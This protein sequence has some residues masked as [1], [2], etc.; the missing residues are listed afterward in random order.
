MRHGES[1]AN[2]DETFAGWLDVP[3]TATG[4]EQARAAGCA[5]REAGLEFDICFT[6]VLQRAT[7]SAWHCLD[8]M[9]RTWLP[10]ERSWRLNE[11]HYG[12]LQGLSKRETVAR[13]GAEQVRAWRRTFETRP[14]ALMCGDASM[15][16]DRRYASLAAGEL[17]LSESMH[18]T[19][20]RLLPLW[21]QGIAPLLASG[22]RPLVIAHGT[23]LRSFAC[24]LGAMSGSELEKLELPNGMPIVFELDTQLR[25]QHTSLAGVNGPTPGRV[26]VASG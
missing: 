18:D 15:A 24:M 21:E 26:A 25:V 11:R 4:V 8:A 1:T 19:V 23:T 5:M 13:F 6:S 9:D 20:L 14:P 17:P 2:L 7:H 22:G 12:A 3:L 10:V 16:H